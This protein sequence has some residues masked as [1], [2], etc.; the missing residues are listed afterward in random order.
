MRELG[1]RPKKRTYGI[2]EAEGASR[3][4]VYFVFFFFV[5]MRE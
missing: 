2:R 5:T 3:A 4:R 1:A